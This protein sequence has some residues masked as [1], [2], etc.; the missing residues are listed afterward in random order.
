MYIYKNTWDSILYITDMYFILD[1]T[2]QRW[3]LIKTRNILPQQ[4][5]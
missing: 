3:N 4:T 5:I 2:E 1:R